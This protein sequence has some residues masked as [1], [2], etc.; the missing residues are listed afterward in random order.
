MTRAVNTALAGSGGVLQ[1]VNVTTSTGVAFSNA[2]ANLSGFSISITP[3][4]ASSKIL[5]IVSI[6]AL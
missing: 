6:P 2:F 4:S 3:S 1:V 5:Y